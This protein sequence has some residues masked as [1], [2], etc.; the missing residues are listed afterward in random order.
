MKKILVFAVIA[1][2]VLA[3]CST[4]SKSTPEDAFKKAVEG[5]NSAQT[6][7]FSV[8]SLVVTEN[9]NLAFDNFGK[10]VTEGNEDFSGKAT[11][12]AQLDEAY[13]DF[14]VYV[15]EGKFYVEVKDQ[16]MALTKEA[17]FDYNLVDFTLINSLVSDYDT[18]TTE[19]D[20]HT[21]V[22]ETDNVASILEFSEFSYLKDF[23]VKEASMKQTITVS[24]DALVSNNI[25]I[26]ATYTDA[27]GVEYP[28]TQQ[29]DLNYS[30]ASKVD[31]PDFAEFK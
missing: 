29:I 27:S 20:V 26:T 18:V 17:L 8:A 19:G 31:M 11:I 28:V 22:K 1:L 12:K 30:A 14:V 25:F 16:K 15:S 23:T 9:G 3:G 5:M 24:K 10:I 21:F 6:V 2:L 7:D 4:G 13:E